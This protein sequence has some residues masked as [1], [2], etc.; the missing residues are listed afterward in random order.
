NCY[1]RCVLLKVGKKLKLQC[2]RACNWFDTKSFPR[3]STSCGAFCQLKS[4]SVNR[5]FLRCSVRT[6]F[7]PIELSPTGQQWGK[8]RALLRS[9]ILLDAAQESP[10]QEPPRCSAAAASP[11]PPPAARSRATES[12]QLFV[13][14]PGNCPHLRPRQLPV[15]TPPTPSPCR[16]RGSPC[17]RQGDDRDC[18]GGLRP[19]SLLPER[20]CPPTPSAPLLRRPNGHRDRLEPLP[21]LHRLRGRAPGPGR[22]FF[23]M[24]RRLWYQ[25][26]GLA[27][28]NSAGFRRLLR[29]LRP[30]E[31]RRNRRGA[32][33]TAR[34][35]APRVCLENFAATAAV[36]GRTCRSCAS[37]AAAGNT[38]SCQVAQI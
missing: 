18:Q 33:G 28:V 35:P 37:G 17:A 32:E 29:G 36:G 20:L 11:A 34:W 38:G 14:N 27:A 25:F 3:N 6:G 26:A 1:R 2:T 23:L 12:P 9:G 13:T 31:N 24:Q 8:C 10:Q 22:D 30:G 5:A 15:A 7:L 19:L 16:A 21:P 4:D